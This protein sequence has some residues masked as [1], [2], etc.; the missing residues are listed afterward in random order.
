MRLPLRGSPSGPSV[1]G[2]P[3][4]FHLSLWVFFSSRSTL[5]TTVAWAN[6]ILHCLPQPTLEV[7][8]AGDNQLVS[9]RAIK[10]PQGSALHEV[11]TL[12]ATK[13]PPTDC[14]ADR[15]F[16]SSFKVLRRLGTHQPVAMARVYDPSWL[17]D[18]V[19]QTPAQDCVLRRLH[20]PSTSAVPTVLV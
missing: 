12:P 11:T 9:H 6:S 4:T 15:P 19:C 5:D 13:P 2:P 14:E 1:D 20:C 3:E 18:P 10:P 17:C 16:C 7:A 8:S